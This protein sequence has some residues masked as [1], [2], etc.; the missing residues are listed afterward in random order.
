MIIDDDGSSLRQKRWSG[1]QRS[2]RWWPLLVHRSRRTL[3]RAS[4]LLC[5]FFFSSRRRHTRFKCDWSSDVCSSD[6]VA[7]VLHHAER[8][9]GPRE[10]ARL[11]GVGCRRLLSCGSHALDGLHFLAALAQMHFILHAREGG[12]IAVGI[13]LIVKL[14]NHAQ[15]ILRVRESFQMPVALSQKMALVTN[16]QLQSRHIVEIGNA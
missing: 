2:R 15:R 11:R 6:L 10:H 5:I 16:L 7:K 4:S 14:V 1:R 3:A 8:V 13:K 9:A 12:G